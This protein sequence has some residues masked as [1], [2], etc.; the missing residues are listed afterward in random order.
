M[1]NTSCSILRAFSINLIG[2]IFFDGIKVK[3]ISFWLHLAN[4]T[5]ILASS[6]ISESVAAVLIDIF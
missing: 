6:S 5:L 1:P 3:R 4:L 2:K